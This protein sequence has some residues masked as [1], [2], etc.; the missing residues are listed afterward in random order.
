[1]STVRQDMAALLDLCWKEEAAGERG[2]DEDMQRY[3]RARKRMA[4]KIVRRASENSCGTCGTRIASDCPNC[5]ARWE[6]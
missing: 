6:S 1:M 5:K 2:D 4:D 3:G